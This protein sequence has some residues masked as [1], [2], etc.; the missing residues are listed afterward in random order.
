MHLCFLLPPSARP[1]PSPSVT[2]PFPLNLLSHFGLQIG[3]W[4]AFLTLYPSRTIPTTQRTPLTLPTPP[5]CPQEAPITIC[6]PTTVPDVAVRPT[7]VTAF[8][9]RPY[10]VESTTSRP[11]CEVKQLQA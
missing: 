5:S 4:K 7:A 10:L 9:V 8:R 3:R 11:I 2:P 6:P 1:T